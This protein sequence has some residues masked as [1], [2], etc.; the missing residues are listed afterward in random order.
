[1]L[2]VNQLVPLAARGIHGPNLRFPSLVVPAEIGQQLSIGTPGGFAQNFTAEVR[3]AVDTLDSQLLVLT[4]RF[5]LRMRGAVR[6]KQNGTTGDK[7]KD[8]EAAH[9][10]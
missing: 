2:S 8:Q 1:M 9:I 5:W 4:L 3:L 10:P 7:A 6:E